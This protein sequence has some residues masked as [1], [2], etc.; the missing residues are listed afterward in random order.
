M[1]MKRSAKLALV[2]MGTAAGVAACDNKPKEPHY[3]SV[4]SCVANGKFDET[5]CRIAFEEASRKHIEKA[6][7]FS[8][9]E[10]CERK[11]GFGRCEDGQS[12]DN[13]F[14]IPLM[15]GYFMGNLGGGG[16]LPYY[17]KRREDDRGGRIGSG[18]YSG[19]SSSSHTQPSATTGPQTTTTASR[20]GFGSTSRS[21]T[22][23]G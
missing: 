7:Q 10:S 18:W 6:P 2:L 23:G 21:F 19:W 13:S 5:Q 20:G 8:S 1:A 11:Y 15:A 16:G 3:G 9:K 12:G 4:E 22:S 17:E 14:W